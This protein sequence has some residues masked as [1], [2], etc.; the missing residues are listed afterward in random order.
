MSELKTEE[1]R[2]EYRWRSNIEAYAPMSFFECFALA[3]AVVLLSVATV[4]LWPIALPMWALAAVFYFAPRVK[5]WIA[6]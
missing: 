2:E 6:K 1:E 4:T 3:F 5:R